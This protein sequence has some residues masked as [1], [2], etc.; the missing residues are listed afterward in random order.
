MLR[1]GKGPTLAIFKCSNT[2]TA[3]SNHSEGV[4]EKC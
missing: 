1:N 2:R 4:M 3:F